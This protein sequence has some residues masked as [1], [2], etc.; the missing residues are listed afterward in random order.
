MT[1]ISNRYSSVD[2]FWGINSVFTYNEFQFIVSVL[3]N[4]ILQLEEIYIRIDEVIKETD[5][6]EHPLIS[7]NNK[8]RTFK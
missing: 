1:L 3:E 7:L 2:N 8:L 6:K 4:L 5:A